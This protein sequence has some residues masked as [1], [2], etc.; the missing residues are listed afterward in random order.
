MIP[1][2]SPKDVKNLSTESGMIFPLPG[3]LHK[4]QRQMSDNLALVGASLLRHD[5]ARRVQPIL[6]NPDGRFYDS[7]VL[8]REGERVAQTLHSPLD[9]KM[10]G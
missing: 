7:R 4:N 6:V 3:P 5:C 2:Q 1:D 9:M 8:Y 10:S